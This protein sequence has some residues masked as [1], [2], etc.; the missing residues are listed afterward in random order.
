MTNN[1]RLEIKTRSRRSNPRQINR[2]EYKTTSTSDVSDFRSLDTT[3]GLGDNIVEPSDPADS[4]ISTI[5]WFPSPE[6]GSVGSLSSTQVESQ[7]GH[8]PYLDPILTT[9]YLDHVFCYL[10]PFYQPSSR[11]GGRSW[12][13]ELLMTSSAFQQIVLSYSTYYYDLTTPPGSPQ[14]GR[15]Q[16]DRLLQAES[17]FKSLIQSLQMLLSVGSLDGHTHCAC[18]VLT[19]I[20]Q[21]H[22][23]EITT[24]NSN[25]KIHFNA[26]LTLFTRL[27][28]KYS[29]TVESLHHSSARA[30]FNA[31]V[32]DLNAPRQ[33][34]FV[35][36]VGIMVFDDIIAAASSYQEPQLFQYHQQLLGGDEPALELEVIIGVKSCI[37]RLLGQ[38]ASLNAKKQQDQAAGNLD[39]LELARRASTI[40][41]SLTANLEQLQAASSLS[42]NPQS[43]ERDYLDELRTPY[44]SRGTAHDTGL[45]SQVWAHAT[46]VYLITVVS[47]WQPANAILRHHVDQIVQVLKGQIPIPLIRT[48]VWPFIRKLAECHLG[49]LRIKSALLAMDEEDP[50]KV[51]EQ[52]CNFELETFHKSVSKEVYNQEMTQKIVAFFK[53]RD[54]KKPTLKSISDRYDQSI[55]SILPCPKRPEDLKEIFPPRRRRVWHCEEP[56]CELSTTKF[57]TKKSLQ[58]HI[59]EEHAKPREDSLDSAQKNLG[60]AVG[61][62]LDG[63]ESDTGVAE[64]LVMPSSDA[65][66]SL[67]VPYT[68]AQDRTQ[69]DKAHRPSLFAN[70]AKRN[71]PQQIATRG[72]LD[73]RIVRRSAINKASQRDRQANLSSSGS[74]K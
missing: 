44:Y 73:G 27:L 2:A 43:V 54:E 47:G 16:V 38:V 25:W 74:G 67:S 48:M 23:Y 20:V 7:A 1:I 24:A 13:L 14:N 12:I 59:N 11:R 69:G 19:S 5:E 56:E 66:R 61:P 22:R 62:E 9:F 31:I 51:A 68:V 17:S 70:P 49:R 30:G 36:S 21:H 41:E 3:S 10:Y 45:V 55:L 52:S 6:S 28:D 72:V 40:M 32:Q 4:A 35:F 29:N 39:G 33:E 64:N 58:Q 63:R 34:A 37:L 65:S 60:L 15:T 42:S 53:R 71:Q 57:K 46:M 18:R 50:L 8:T 26:A